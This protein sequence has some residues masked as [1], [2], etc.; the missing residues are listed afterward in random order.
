MWSNQE[1]EVKTFSK[2]LALKL[3][4]LLDSLKRNKGGALIR[5]ML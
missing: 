4:I 1:S 3:I 5:E 2:I